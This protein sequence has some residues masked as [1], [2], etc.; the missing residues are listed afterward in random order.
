M[1]K[2][3]TGNTNRRIAFIEFIILTFDEAE[4]C[5]VRLLDVA[6]GLWVP[7]KHTLNGMDA[8]DG[9]RIVQ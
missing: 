6:K 1:M 4:V 3:K 5:C 7:L 2:I 9:F 8:E